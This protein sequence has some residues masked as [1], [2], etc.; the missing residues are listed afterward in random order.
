MFNRADKIAFFNALAQPGAWV[1]RPPADIPNNFL[2]DRPLDFLGA[3]HPDDKTLFN[4][5]TAVA[6][7]LNVETNLPIYK[8]NEHDLTSEH[9]FRSRMGR[10]WR[11]AVMMGGHFVDLPRNFAIERT[12]EGAQLVTTPN[13]KERIVINAFVAARGL[14]IPSSIFDVQKIRNFDLD[15]FLFYM[16]SGEPIADPDGQAWRYVTLQGHST[17]SVLNGIRKILGEQLNLDGNS[18][19]CVDCGEGVHMIM[20]K[21]DT[22]QDC[23]RRFDATYELIRAIETGQE[24]GADAEPFLRQKLAEGASPRFAGSKMVSFSQIIRQSGR[25]DFFEALLKI[26]GSSETPLIN[27]DLN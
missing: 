21:E 10:S 3:R 6:L 25:A 20:I 2:C 4:I 19:S 16:H 17:N 26:E 5:R 13:L 1:Y 11:H 18:F 12:D 8:I 27:R 23:Q 15:D 22:L 24:T 14:E 9:E 7:D